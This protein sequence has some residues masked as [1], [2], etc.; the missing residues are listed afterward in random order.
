MATSVTGKATEFI[1]FTR[2]SNA[3]V[4]DS[5]GKVKW[6]PHNLLLAS[7]QFDSASWTKATITSSNPSVVANAGVAPN[8]TITA[9][10]V[11]YGVID[12]A[13]D[14]STVSQLLTLDAAT[15]TGG[16]WIKAVAAGDVGKTVSVYLNDGSIRGQVFVTV[17]ADW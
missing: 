2:A 15:Y 12:A 3:T 4:T 11:N 7:E 6:A 8:G 13:G 14:V 10:R 17:T 9:D 16:V 5:D 1:Q